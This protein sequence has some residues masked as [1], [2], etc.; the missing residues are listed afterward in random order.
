[1]ARELRAQGLKLREIAERMGVAT[2]TAGAYLS[3]PGGKQLAARKQALRGRCINCGSPCDGASGNDRRSL[4]CQACARSHATETR[5]WTLETAT[6]AIRAWTAEH[7]RPPTAEDTR[8]DPS[9]PTWNTT[10]I[11]EHGGWRLFLVSL[12]L[13]AS[14]DRRGAGRGPGH[15][16]A[17][18]LEDAV[19]AYREH[20]SC[21]AAGRAL[22]VSGNTVNQRMNRTTEGRKLLMSNTNGHKAGESR[23][24]IVLRREAERCGAMIDQKR[25]EIAALEAERAQIEGALEQLK[26]TA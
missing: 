15:V 5:K 19:W 23:A 18:D 13:K 2:S 26:A 8:V 24:V 22:G 21:E 17:R 25:K 9:L 4:R 6:A 20:G 1:V 3:D 14:T 16:T 11:G 7:G 12:G 10:V